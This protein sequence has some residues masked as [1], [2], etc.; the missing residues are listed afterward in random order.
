MSKHDVLKLL[1]C[2]VLY[3]DSNHNNYIFIC[4]LLVLSYRIYVFFSEYHLYVVQSVSET[5]PDLISWST[6][7]ELQ[8]F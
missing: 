8:K 6:E 7:E 2:L 4:T 5:I 1:K 3:K